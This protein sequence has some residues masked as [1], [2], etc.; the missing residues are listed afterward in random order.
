MV[1][2]KAILNLN[3]QALYQNF[4]SNMVRLKAFGNYC[5]SMTFGEFQFQYGSIK[6]V[7]ATYKVLLLLYFNSNMVRLKEQSL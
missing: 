4:N 5:Y 7:D 2:L 3:T 6:S 1:R